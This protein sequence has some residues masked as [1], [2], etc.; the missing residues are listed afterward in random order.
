MNAAYTD[1]IRHL[2]ELDVVLVKKGFPPTSPW[3]RET[4][5]RWYASGRR[6]LTVRAGRR[7]GKSS[8]LCRL[9]VI[10]ALYGEHDVPPGDVGVVAVVSTRRNEALERLRTIRAI[11]DALG[12]KYTAKVESIELH[13]HPVVFTVFTASI[14]G[15]SGFTAIFVLCDE[16]SKWRDASSGVNPANEV[17]GSIRP[18][19]LTQRN[20]KIVLSSSPMGKKDA[21]ALEYAQG[22]T[23]LQIVAYAPSWIA[24][25]S[26]TEEDTHVLEPNPL[27]WAREYA[28]IPQDEDEDSI[29]SG[30]MLDRQTRATGC[31][32]PDERHHYTAHL[33]F[34][35]DE[36]VLAIGSLTD[37]N[38]R[39]IDRVHAWGGAF[40]KWKHVARALKPYGIK[41]VFCPDFAEASMREAAREAEVGLASSDWTTAIL[42]S[43][44]EELRTLA[45]GTLLDLTADE[46]V[47]TALLGIRAHGTG[48]DVESPI[49][50]CVAMLISA[51]RA[52]PKPLPLTP[53]QEDESFKVQYLAD[54]EKARKRLERL[55]PKILRFR[56]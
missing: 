1:M 22:E 15:V 27:V 17:I 47:R 44:Y 30:A 33:D 20:A 11:L 46:D 50:P 54:R 8:S 10:E 25:P 32:V 5:R 41:H 34:R 36:W 38:V 13:D 29:I 53:A 43:A 49:A 2:D 35:S 56:R 9:A 7:G 40:P 24:N 14:A 52:P 26:V 31:L 16:V 23:S 12:E 28:A 39:R 18:T 48:Y 4:F 51:L 37:G 21:H 3:W 42:A 19:L 6:Q 55:Q 45:R